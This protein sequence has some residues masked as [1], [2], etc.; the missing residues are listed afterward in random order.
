M[1]GESESER[2][3]VRKRRRGKES[4]DEGEKRSGMN[5]ISHSRP[6]ALGTDED[7]HLALVEQSTS[8]S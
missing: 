2:G 8:V 1:C 3:C 6:I 7:G 5:F 4:F